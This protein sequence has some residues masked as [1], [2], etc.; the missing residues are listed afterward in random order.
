LDFLEGLSKK[1]VWKNLCKYY[2]KTAIK[3]YE[4]KVT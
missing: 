4:V 2:N 3:F 1:S